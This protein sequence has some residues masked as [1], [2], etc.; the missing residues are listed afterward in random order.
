MQNV[1]QFLFSSL[2]N[3]PFSVLKNFDDFGEFLC[4]DIKNIDINTQKLSKVQGLCR[5][6]LKEN[7]G[8]WRR[9]IHFL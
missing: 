2:Q 8:S 7:K 1:V 6:Y 4:I 5:E 9:H 3:S